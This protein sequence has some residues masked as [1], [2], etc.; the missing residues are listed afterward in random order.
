MTGFGSSETGGFRIEIR[1]LNHRF[2]DISIKCPPAISKHE[3]ALREILKGKFMRG[4]FDVY[5]SF[6]GEVGVKTKLNKAMANEVFAMLT[7]LK[8][9]LDIEEAIRI[10]ALLN[11]RDLF[12]DEEVH[13]DSEALFETFNE[14]VMELE[15]MRLKEGKALSS[16][17]SSRVDTIEAL[18]K[19]IDSKCPEILESSKKRFLERL[20]TFFE[21][22]ECDDHR[23]LQEAAAL[24]EKCDITEEVVRLRGHIE[25]IRSILSE[26]GA[27]GRKMDFLVQELHREANT[28]ASKAGD[29]RVSESVVSMKA[30]IERVREQVQNVQ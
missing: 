3:I 11:W 16:D 21:G 20:N 26:E 8:E 23:L 7:E 2:M 22:F 5:I 13:Y 19:G 6:L 4:K 30:E 24:A 25:H 10:E 17:I 12:I 18:N 29:P 14:A 9:E 28:I 27:V 1:S 15:R